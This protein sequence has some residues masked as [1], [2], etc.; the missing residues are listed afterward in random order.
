MI[1]VQKLSEMDCLFKKRIW[2]NYISME[3]KF[4]K[5]LID[6]INLKRCF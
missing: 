6:V 3:K 4:I 5:I 2:W 1:E